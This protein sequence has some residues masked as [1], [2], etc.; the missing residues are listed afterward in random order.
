MN[1]SVHRVNVHVINTGTELLLGDVVN[2]HLS[3][4]ARAILPLGLRVARQFTVPDGPAIADAL[5]TSFGEAQIVFVTGG[6][7]PT[8]DDVTR[9]TAA[10]LLQLALRLDA[11]VANT[12]TSR[13]AARKI[14][15]TD[16]ILRQAQVPQ[17]AVAL[18]NE[19]GTAPGLYLAAKV[20][21][22]GKSP[23]LFLL[24]GPPRELQ[25]MFKTEVLQILERIAPPQEQIDVQTFRLA[26]IGESVIEKKV[27]PQILALNGVELGY[28]ARPAEVD[29]RI[30]GPSS[31]VKE[32]ARILGREFQS[33]IFT[34]TGESLESVVIRLLTTKRAL[35]ATAE[36]C[37][38]GLLAHRL[39][40]VP[41]S[42]AAYTGGY[43]TYGNELKSDSLGVAASLIATH[44]A[45][46]KP[47]AIAMAEGARARA[48]THFALATTG[49]AGPDGGT[50]DKPVG[51]VYVALARENAPTNVR[52]FFFPTDRETFKQM[53][54]QFA[55]EMLRQSLTAL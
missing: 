37:T 42:S 29:V 44:G 24:P 41:G 35:L 45:V 43:I 53:T 14:E 16:R 32:A 23:H 38:G 50:P 13:L 47:V 9:E 2:T 52:R 27:G 40:N 8:T 49:I 5:R 18:A 34:S 7:G 22:H 3:F 21:L 33:S 28:C 46:S 31:S 36:S 39:T 10:E 1:G 12:I 19:H 51:T 4:I 55:L 20:A 26:G 30:I 17:G 25:P 6:L 54:T 15:L 11:D 48:H